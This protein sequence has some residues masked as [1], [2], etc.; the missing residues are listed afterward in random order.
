MDKYIAYFIEFVDMQI[1][2]NVNDLEEIRAICEF[3]CNE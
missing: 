2:N 3:L 1:Q